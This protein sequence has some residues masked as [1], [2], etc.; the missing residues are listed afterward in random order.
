MLLRSSPSRQLNEI[1][2]E[3]YRVENEFKR[4]I[5]YKMERFSSS[6]PGMF[7]RYKQNMIFVLEQ[8]KQYLEF[9]HKKLLMNDP[10]LQYRK[11]WSQVSVDGKTIDLEGIKIE[12]KFILEDDTSRMEALCL[13]KVNKY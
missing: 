2:T 4:V 9:M 1:Q 11:G 13:S 6:L 8:K 3:F 5:Q 10:K 7:K 12:Q